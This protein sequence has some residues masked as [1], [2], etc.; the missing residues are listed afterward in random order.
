[1]K[2]I[3]LFLLSLL[4]LAGCAADESADFK[5]PG[6]LLFQVDIN[7]V[8]TKLGRL[9][10]DGGLIRISSFQLDGD[11]VEAEDYFFKNGYQ[12][13]LEILFDSLQIAAALQFDLPQ[14]IYNTLQL[15]FEI[16]SA[17]IPTLIVVGRLK[18]ANGDWLPLMLEVDSFENF[19]FLARNANGGQELVFQEGNVRIGKIEF[20]PGHWF[21]GISIE[22]LEAA[23]RSLHNGDSILLINRQ[24]N[25]DFYTEIDNRLDE[26]NQLTI[27]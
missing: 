15:N 1:M 19:S 24:V 4:I 6:A 9:E 18:K 16:P 5:A 10:F 11:R 7:R 8:P 26:L 2:R 13:P 20:N 27:Q 22:Q 23:P 3:Q 17:N 25:S 12:P 14:G 21:S